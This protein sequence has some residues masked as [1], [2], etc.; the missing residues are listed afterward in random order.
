MH[1]RTRSVA[2]VVVASLA[3]AASSLTCGGSSGGSCGGTQPCGGDVTGNWKASSACVDSTALNMAVLGDVATDCPNA[4]ITNVKYTP[5]GTLTFGSGMSYTA[6]V[7]MAMSFNL[8]IPTSCISGG[9]TCADAN[10]GIQGIVGMDGITSAT[11]TGTTTCVCTVAGNVD[12][13]NSAGTYS[14]A[15]TV[16]TLTATSGGNGDSGD[17]CVKGSSLHLITVDMSMAMAKITGDIVLTK[18]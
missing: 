10:T 9:G 13:E 14:T 5:S 7:T 3:L 15:G 16:L 2:G 1:T 11:C 4:S 18:Q 6:A 12:V 17:Y 8:N